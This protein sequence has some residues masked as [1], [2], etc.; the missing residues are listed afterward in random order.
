MKIS[1]SILLLL[2][3][4]ST[5]LLSQQTF[6]LKEAQDYAVENNMKVKNA[7][8]D[9]EIADKKVWETTAQGL[10]QVSAKGSF[11]NNAVLPTTVVPANTFNPLAPSDELV[12]LKFGTDFNINGTLSVSQLVFSGNYLVGL[13]ASKMYTN[14]S[15]TLTEKEKV[16]VRK[17]VTQ[18][19]YTVLILDKNKTILDSTLQTME[20]LLGETNILVEEKVIEST[21][22]DQLS[23][24]VM[25]VKNGISQVENQITVAKQALNFQLGLPLNTEVTLSTD[26]SVFESNGKII[27]NSSFSITN[28]VNKQLLDVQLHLNELSLKNTKANFLPT[29]SAFYSLQRTAQRNETDFFN[30][31]KPWYPTAVIGVNLNIPIFSSGMRLSQ[32]NQAKL[33]VEK[34][35]NTIEQTDVAL[36]LQLNQAIANYNTALN[37]YDIAISSEKVAKKVLENTTIKYKEGVVNSL[38]LTQAQNQYLQAQ[39]SVS[40]AL[41]EVI[42]SKIELNY[43]TNNF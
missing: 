28:N 34:T 40:N 33:E 22:S 17:D 43:I 8:L 6:S 29:L 16:D 30:S 5:N 32:V 1:S 15:A 41:F 36:Q 7:I 12:G 24:S 26:L 10:P 21:N 37:S 39:T 9:Q 4:S 38:E 31:D 42:K 25:Q 23:L 14:L 27:E 11:Q 19:Y 35:A 18:A 20:K 3:L 2:L 13:Q